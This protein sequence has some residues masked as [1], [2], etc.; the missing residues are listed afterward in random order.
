MLIEIKF[1]VMRNTIVNNEFKQL[2]EIV[3]NRYGSAVAHSGM[4]ASFKYWYSS[5]LK[6]NIRLR[7]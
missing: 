3:E 7:I 1:N 6:L 5:R 2:R 4:I